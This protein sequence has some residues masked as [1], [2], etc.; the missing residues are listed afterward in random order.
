MKVHNESSKC[1]TIFGK[2]G[3]CVKYGDCNV[4]VP[5]AVFNI[6]FG[7]P[8][9]L[10]TTCESV[11]NQ[12]RV[13]CPFPTSNDIYN[14]N[15]TIF[16]DTTTT[17]YKPLYPPNCGVT[18]F[19]KTKIVGGVPSRRWPW[20]A[21]IGYRIGDLIA[22][23]CDGTLISDQHIIT[24]GHCVSDNNEIVLVRL[25]DYDLYSDNDGTIPM[26]YLVDRIKVHPNYVSK[27]TQN[28]IAII[29]L[30]DKIT[31]TSK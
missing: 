25:G 29:R 16:D 3:Y 13:C 26:D 4:W 8:G 11:N 21:A 28:D 20:V 22:V 23:L 9:S 12:I 5:P 2:P 18:N 7:Q 27:F 15:Q 19:R 30:K 10:K 6:L 31:F 14:P 1:Q 17:L 24:A